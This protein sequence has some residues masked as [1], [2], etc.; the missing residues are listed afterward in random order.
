MNMNADEREEFIE[1]EKEF[2]KFNM[3]FSHLNDCFGGGEEAVNADANADAK[4]DKQ[5]E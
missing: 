5:G 2:F 3:R 4:K 1:K